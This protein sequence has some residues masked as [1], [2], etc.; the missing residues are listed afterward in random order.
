[1]P[2]NRVPDPLRP[3]KPVLDPPS[4]LAVTTIPPNGLKNV[5]KR[6]K[7]LSSTLDFVFRPGRPAARPAN[8]WFF[9]TS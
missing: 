9:A 6:Q 4:R 3:P 5:K 7:S 8:T 2:A 1:M